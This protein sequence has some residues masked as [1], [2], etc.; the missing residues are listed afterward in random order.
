LHHHIHSPA[1]F[2]TAVDMS[3]G[4]NLPRMSLM[5][6]LAAAINGPTGPRATLSH[7]L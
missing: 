5:Y 7:G 6:A 2:E 1:P 3:P 4:G